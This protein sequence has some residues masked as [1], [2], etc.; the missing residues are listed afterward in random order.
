ME[1]PLISTGANVI[2]ICRLGHRLLKRRRPLINT[3]RRGGVCQVRIHGPYDKNDT[4][5]VLTINYA[6]CAR[7]KAQGASVKRQGREV[8]GF[9]GVWGL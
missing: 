5:N 9:V 6:T 8:L 1:S 4:T 3:L 7:L 2:M